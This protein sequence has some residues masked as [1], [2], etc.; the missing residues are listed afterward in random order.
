[1]SARAATL[2]DVAAPSPLA[3]PRVLAGA[4]RDRPVALAEHLYAHGELG[5]RPRRGAAA[6]LLELVEAS[7][8]QGR[9]GAAFPTG[10]KLRAV[11]DAGRRPVVLANGAE[12]EPVSGKDQLLLAHVP[13]LVLD[14]AA[15]AAA[16]V[17]ARE[18]VIAIGA[19]ARQAMTAVRAATAERERRRLDRVSFQLVS[20]PDRFV[21]GE[22]TALV[23]RL[24]GGPAIP[25]FTPPRPFERGVGG[26]PTLV[27]NVETLAHLAL[28]ARFGSDW[29]RALGTPAEPGSALVTLGGAVRQPGIYEI[30]LGLPFADLLARAGGPSAPLQAFLIGGY[31]GAWISA[32]QARTLALLDSD[33]Q[34]VGAALGARAIFALPASACGIVETARVARYLAQE[35]AG[36]CGPCVNGL[37][38][39]AA[40]LEQ[41]AFGKHGRRSLDARLDR[42]LE[43]VQGRGACRHPDGAAHLV[44][45]GLRTFAAERE[46]HA[47]GSCSGAGRPL[48]PLENGRVGGR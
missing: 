4:H 22:E 32:E 41:L 48:L 43:Q 25:T 10:R 14:G 39:I 38:A 8:L 24:N 40:A 27:Q 3:L 23:N 15:V 17:G 18:A 9:G 47:H 2:P 21:A 19:G 30:P 44:A 1:V 7:G 33:L 36:Q 13:H 6:E 26:A 46:R 11:A 29:F 20:V 35:S 42:W 31:F 5:L 28:I 37:D 34:T 16:A 45:S 12:G